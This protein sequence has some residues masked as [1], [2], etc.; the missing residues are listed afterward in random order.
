MDGNN[1]FGPKERALLLGVMAESLLRLGRPDEAA[2]LLDEAQAA[3]PKD[4]WLASLRDEQQ[5]T[6][7]GSPVNILMNPSFA[8]SGSWA[9]EFWGHASASTSASSRAPAPTS[10]A[11]SPR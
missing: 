7:P 10:A 6:R 11:R 1:R 4:G 3:A 2:P 9:G 8:R 5:A